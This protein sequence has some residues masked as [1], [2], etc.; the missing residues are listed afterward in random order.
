ME[1]RAKDTLTRFYT[2][3]SFLDLLN[4]EIVRAKRYSRPLALLLIQLRV[5]PD[6]N[7]RESHGQYPVLK[8]SSRVVRHLIRAVDIPGR[9]ADKLV[10]ALPETAPEGAERMAQR[11][12]GEFGTIELEEEG[13]S[14]RVEGEIGISIFPKDGESGEALLE[15]ARQAI[16][17]A[18]IKS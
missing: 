8:Q 17:T 11:I 7:M 5:H 2:E 3:A 15:S 9:M 4:Q 12:L 18:P 6:A 10:L 1:N 13:L 14:V 16:L